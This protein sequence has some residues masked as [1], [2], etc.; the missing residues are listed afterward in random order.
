MFGLGWSEILILALIG[1]VLIG[2]KQLP[3]MMKGLAKFFKEVS[4][5]RDDWMHTVRTDDSIREIQ[6]SVNEVKE[7]IN[8][9]IRQVKKSIEDE[10]QRHG[11]PSLED[12][13]EE[14]TEVYDEDEKTS[15][16]KDSSDPT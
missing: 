2:P 16:K 8:K 4:K 12:A 15:L 3:E 14:M 11:K 13:L 9:P 6:E 10:L 5:A 1:L 7:S